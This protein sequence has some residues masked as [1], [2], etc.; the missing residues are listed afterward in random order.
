M[1]VRA[2]VFDVGETLADET[3]AWGE[4][5]DW[6]GVPRLTFFGVLGGVIERGQ[7]HREVFGLLRPGF[8]HAREAAA[9]RA[10]G[11]GWRIRSEDLYPDTLPCLEA[12]RAEGYRL[13]VA[14][15]QSMTQAGLI[16]DLGLPVDVVASSGD[17][18]VAKPDPAFFSRV[19][20]AVGLP[21]DQIAYVGDRVD[22]DVLPAVAAGMT[23]VFVR[24]GPWGMLHSVLPAAARAHVRVESLA[25]LPAAL[26]PFRDR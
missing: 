16:R 19:A 1:G 26:R 9:K 8:D 5:A 23:A 24:R 10:A 20:E 18:G 7:D 3:A 14:G 13:G 21:P 2:V 15:N 12:L 17:W 11:R 4:W 6:M 25:E 22:N